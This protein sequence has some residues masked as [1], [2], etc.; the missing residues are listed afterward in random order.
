MTIFNGI[1]LFRLNLVIFMSMVSLI[2]FSSIVFGDEWVKIGSDEE[3][4]QYY[5]KS[6][7][8][9]GKQNKTIEVRLK[10]VFTDKGKSDFLVKNSK[11]KIKYSDISFQSKEYLLNYKEWKYSMLFISYNSQS[12]KSLF[13]REYLPEWK[14]IIS[15]TFLDKLTNHLVK[16][17]KIKK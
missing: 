13:H 10:L 7:V 3:F 11:S 2:A 9:I 16:D 8:K 17:Y 6:S 12:G 14:D 4:T 15:D 5:N 1:K